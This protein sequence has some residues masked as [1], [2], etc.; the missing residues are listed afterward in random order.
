MQISNIRKDV[1][2]SNLAWL[3]FGM[4]TMNRSRALSLSSVFVVVCLFILGI[5]M[6]SKP[7]ADVKLIMG[8]NMGSK[9]AADV[10]TAA[11][12]TT[13]PL[14]VVAR[15]IDGMNSHNLEAYL[16]A[17]HQDVRIF[18]YPGIAIGNGRSHLRRIFGPLL[19]QGIGSIEVL[20]QVAIANTVISV[21]LVNYGGDE[22]QHIVAIYSVE[23]GLISSI[24]LIESMD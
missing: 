12:A 20:Y 7:A 4:K 2:V 9:P 18:E 21:E 17:H 15:R 8:I 14:S 16:T 22:M 24:Q 23:D 6:G 11:P 3:D 5:N 10:K 13:N 1:A 19:E